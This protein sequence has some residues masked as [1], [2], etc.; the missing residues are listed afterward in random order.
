MMLNNW[1]GCLHFD[2]KSDVLFAYLV[3]VCIY[4]LSVVLKHG[5]C[6]TRKIHEV[7]SHTPDNLYTRLYT[8]IEIF[9]KEI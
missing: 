6:A 4:A 8:A 3:Y 7:G 2:M 9:F 5:V 1:F